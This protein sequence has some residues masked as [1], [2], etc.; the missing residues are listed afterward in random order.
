[1]EKLHF[2]RQNFVEDRDYNRKNKLGDLLAQTFILT[3]TLAVI[4]GSIA[5]LKFILS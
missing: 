5:T 2:H 4:L 1:M 3:S